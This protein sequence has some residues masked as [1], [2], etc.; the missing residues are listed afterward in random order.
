ML[1][2]AI[3]EDDA[4]Q[5]AALCNITEKF[6]TGQGESV[7]ILTF[8]DGGNILRSYPANLD[9]ILMDIDM[10]KVDGLTAAKKIREYDRDV[11][12]VFITNMV[13]YALEGYSVEAMDFIAKPLTV[14]G[15]QL[16]FS[17]VLRRLRQNRGKSISVRRGKNVFSVS[18]ANILYAETQGHELLL[19]MKDGSCMTVTES[20]K[21][22]EERTREF[23]FFRCHTSYVVNLSAVETIGK[24]DTV[25]AGLVL[26]VSKYRRSEF[27]EA[28]ACFAGGSC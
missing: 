8:P 28:M 12:L 27:L 13:Q 3:V 26:P 24:T 14:Y 19:H 4:A 15:C 21:S 9:L 16:S 20:I 6:F 25:V 2:I 18:T 11:L 7:R 17:R 10:P 23:G 22:F 5:R 1:N